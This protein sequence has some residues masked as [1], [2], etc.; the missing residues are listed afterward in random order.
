M[1]FLSAAR[2]LPARWMWKNVTRA[3][4]AWDRLNAAGKSEG[5]RPLALKAGDQFDKEVL[6]PKKSIFWSEGLDIK[7]GITTGRGYLKVEL[8][9][10]DKMGVGIYQRTHIH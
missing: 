9:A 5:I 7:D 1:Q 2:T 6:L 8:I 10:L 3:I 4:A